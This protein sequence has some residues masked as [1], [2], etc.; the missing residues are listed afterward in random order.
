MTSVLADMLNRIRNAKA[1]KHPAVDVPLSSMTRGVA[2]IL[3]EK[4]F[5]KGAEVKGKKGRKVLTLELKYSDGS[6]ALMGAECVSKPG[7][8]IY[9]SMDEIRKVK[10]RRG[11][12]ILSTSKGLMADKEAQRE[13]VGGELLCIVW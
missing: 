2:K 8:R 4:G 3:E 13:R 11:I 9:V 6:S 10:K 5:I 7:Q 12:A 1:V